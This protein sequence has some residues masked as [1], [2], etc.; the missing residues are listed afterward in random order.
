MGSGAELSTAGKVLVV[1]EF[2]PILVE[3]L[4]IEPWRIPVVVI[5]GVG[6]YLVFLLMIRIFGARVLSRMTAFDAVVLTMV[7][8]VAGRVIIGHPPT[9]AAGVIGLITLML[10]E[11]MFGAA[12][13]VSSGLRQ[14]FDGRP[15]IVLVHGEWIFEELRKTH[16]AKSD[17]RFAI[18]RA[19]IH[20][21]DMVQCVILEPTG[22]LS[23]FREG[24]PVDPELLRGV[25]GVDRLY[26]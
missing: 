15:R 9:L 8:A 20:R 14:T 24:T 13:S 22:E 23:I 21:M 4:T 18:R 10:L 26:P 6:V 17:V 1:Q 2:K 19:G 16:L 5:A 7:G 11:A 12:R 25:A 3:Q